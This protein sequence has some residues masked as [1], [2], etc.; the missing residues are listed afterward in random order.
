[1]AH[2]SWLFLLL[3][4]MLLVSSILLAVNL[5]WYYKLFKK[6]QLEGHCGK[7]NKSNVTLIASNTQTQG[8][9]LCTK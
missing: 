7:C 6:I 1:M 5:Y 3:C 4:F 2:A 9:S 8:E